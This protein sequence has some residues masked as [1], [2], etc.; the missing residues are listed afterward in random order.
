MQ[1]MYNMDEE[2]TSHKIL[3]TDTY[4]S[5]NW[6]SSINEIAMDHVKLIEGKNGP[7]TF[8]PLNTEISGQARYIKDKEAVCLMDDQARHVYKKGRIRKHNKCVYN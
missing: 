6:V 5:L 3:M 7:T 8:L 1:K 4:D 2:Q